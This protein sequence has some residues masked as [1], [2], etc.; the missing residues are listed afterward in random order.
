MALGWRHWRRME[1]RWEMRVATKRQPV[2][3]RHKALLRFPRAEHVDPGV[4]RTGA[5]GHNKPVFFCDREGQLREKL[6]L[7][8]I[9]DGAR[10]VYCQLRFGHHPFVAV[11]DRSV[12]VAA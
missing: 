12:M 6:F 3:C 9:E 4:W 8:L 11:G 7:P 5:R 10:P 1:E 2:G